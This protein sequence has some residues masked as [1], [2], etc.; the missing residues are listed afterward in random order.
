MVAEREVTMR[1]PDLDWQPDL[2]DDAV[3][4]A[5]SPIVSRIIPQED[6]GALWPAMRRA[7]TAGAAG[8]PGL[9]IIQISAARNA[10]N[11]LRS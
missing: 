9:A 4:P 6:E 5:D 2:F 11:V 1:V 7:W 8:A 3:A 10:I